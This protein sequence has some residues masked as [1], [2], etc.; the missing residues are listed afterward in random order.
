MEGDDEKNVRT[1]GIFV[2]NIS[3]TREFHDSATDPCPAERHPS[4]ASAPSSTGTVSKNEHLQS[5]SE[6]TGDSRWGARGSLSIASST[7]NF[8]RWQL[9]HES[10]A[11]KRVIDGS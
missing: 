6:R 2:F 5:I 8:A 11:Y 3:S 4:R 9:E 7:S 10:S 1:A